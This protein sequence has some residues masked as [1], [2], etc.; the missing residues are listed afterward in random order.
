MAKIKFKL[1]E[2]V[3]FLF[4]MAILY[5]L[6]NLIPITVVLAKA[7][8]LEPDIAQ[9]LQIYNQLFWAFIGVIVLVAVNYIWKGN[10]KYGDNIGIFNK[11]EGILKGMTYPQITLLS[12]IVFPAIFFL[13]NQ[14][15]I[16]GKG[17]FGLQFIPQ[18]FSK[19]DSL[20]VNTLQIPITENL[21]LAAAIGFIL[22]V[23]T[24]LAVYYKWDKIKTI[25]YKYI[26]VVVSSLI[27]GMLWHKTAYPN[28]DIAIIV[29]GI[30]WAI[31]GLISLVTGSMI[32]FIAMH[33][34]NN[35]FIDFAQL[36]TNDLLAGIMIG[37]LILMSAI[38]YF[39]FKGNLW[40]Q[41]GR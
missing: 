18:Q 16:L 22:T 38:Y 4:F 20:I 12:F 41:K 17:I 9:Q 30:F 1:P 36:Y 23:V 27:L 25:Q 13:A 15:K 40:G 21:F 37:Y 34:S 29:V 6:G 19:I 7:G 8:F 31:G 10:N 32:P 5:I 2:I 33:M 11:E 3:G 26:I 24:L 28:S 14:I 39:S 35:F